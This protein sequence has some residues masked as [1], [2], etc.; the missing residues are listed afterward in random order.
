MASIGDIANE[1]KALLEDI[2]T[3]TLGTRNNTTQII[4]ELH[5]LEGEVTQLDQDTKTGFTNLAAGVQVLIQLGAQANQLSAENL[6]QNKTIIC[7][8]D[9][10]A[11][12][13]C[14]VK[15]DLDAGLVEQRGMRARLTHID[16]VLELV[17]AREAVE[18]AHHDKLQGEID[19]C[20]KREP[21]PPAP[22]F[23]DC[24]SRDVPPFKPIR[25]TWKPVSFPADKGPDQPR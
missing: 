10:I 15:H 11:H 6:E 23:E 24:K 8:L 12:V 16:A 2:K 14:D 22:C 19:A 20:C 18:V 5:T 1:A 3:N 25:V 4:N 21:Q 13:L 9:K 7:W 17:H